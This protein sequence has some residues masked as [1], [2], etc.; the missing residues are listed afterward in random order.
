MGKHF[1]PFGQLDAT[2]LQFTL[3]VDR[4]GKT[5]VNMTYGPASGDVALISAPA[6]TMWPRATG[7]GNFGTMWGPTDVTKAKFTLDLTDAPINEQP[8]LEFDQFKRVMET[9]DDKLLDFVTANQLK[10]LG[11]KNLTRDEVKMLQIRSI[12]P[13]FDKMTGTLT[14]NS[15]N[16][17]TSKFA[18]DGMGGKYARQVT[19]CDHKGVTVPNG[20]VSPGDVV[21]ATIY[22]NQVYTGVGGDKF[23]VHWGFQDCSV[24]CQRSNLEMKTEVSAFTET[25]W[26]F[27]RAYVDQVSELPASN[28]D[29]T[30]QFGAATPA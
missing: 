7:D 2:L 17:S 15:L 9:I 19:I 26:A 5:Q 6:I 27:G 3:G 1:L 23:G 12:R 8:N 24:I 29:A 16:L 18:W 30:S 21:A 10:I 22:A 13:K 28:Y 4:A 14:G 25:D 11:R 20:T